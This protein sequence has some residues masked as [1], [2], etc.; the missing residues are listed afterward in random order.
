MAAV[1]T[2]N[3]IIYAWSGLA[4]LTGAVSSDRDV[5]CSFN[6][7]GDVTSSVILR[8]SHAKG[9]AY[10]QEADRHDISVRLPRLRI[11]GHERE[12][13]GPPSRDPT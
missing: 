6:T 7:L 3:R 11:Q 4:T 2:R 12:R 8:V 9:K 10:E 5:A 13:T 1:G